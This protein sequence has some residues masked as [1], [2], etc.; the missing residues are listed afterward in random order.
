MKQ[1]STDKQMS[2]EEFKKQAE[3]FL[4]AKYPAYVKDYLTMIKEASE[5]YWEDNWSPQAMV[6]G[7]VTG[8]A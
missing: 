1:E 8:L 2:L 6:A 3:S 5:G 7:I 4:R